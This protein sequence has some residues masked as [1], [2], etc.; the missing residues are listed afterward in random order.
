MKNQNYTVTI[1]VAKSPKVVFNQ[2]NDVSRWWS[3]DFC[4]PMKGLLQKKNVMQGVCR[5][6]SGITEK[7]PEF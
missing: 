2:I 4:L 5:A 6:G 3:K 7:R 1:E